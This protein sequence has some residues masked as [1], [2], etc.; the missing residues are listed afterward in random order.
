MNSTNSSTA[1]VGQDNLLTVLTTL[2]FASRCYSVLFHFIFAIILIFSKKLHTRELLY[3]NHST[4]VNS[5]YCLMFFF[6]MFSDRPNFPNETLNNILCSMS[7]IA[8]PFSHF[9]RMY[10]I[11]LIAVYRFLAVFKMHLYKKLNDSIV[12]LLLP[13]GLV[14]CISIGIPITLKNI[15]GTTS[16]R[17][18][19]SDG[20]ANSQRTTI[21]YVSFH[22]FFVMITP[23]ICIIT[24]YALIVFKLNKLRK[25]VH[26]IEVKTIDVEESVSIYRTNIQTVNNESLGTQSGNALSINKSKGDLNTKKQRKFANQFILMCCCVLAISSAVA[27]FSLR[28][29]IPNYTSVFL[30]WRPIMRVYIL[31]TLTIIPLI[32]LYFHPDKARIMKRIFCKKSRVASKQ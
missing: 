4:I 6:Y 25:K 2:D 30:Y 12:F 20:G 22:Y 9:I 7:E 31:T 18:F 11:L 13:I 29:V 1:T 32:S 23:S 28:N 8:W 26:K 14:W 10:S 21:F 24:I 16:S 5:F 17:I 27:I 19:C 3:V 15:F